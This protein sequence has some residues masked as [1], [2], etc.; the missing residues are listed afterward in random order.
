MVILLAVQ[1]LTRTAGELLRAAGR[2]PEA[3]GA[4]DMFPLLVNVLAQANIP[5]IHLI[6]VW[7][8]Y[9]PALYAYTLCVQEFLYFLFF[10]ILQCVVAE[11]CDTPLTSCLQHYL[12]SYTA[13]EA[14]GE[15]GVWHTVVF[16]FFCNCMG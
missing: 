8:S 11:L 16:L 12:T 10:S 4:D 14:F 15:A 3:L 13:V 9:W 5:C 6:L 2:H 7:Y 1:W